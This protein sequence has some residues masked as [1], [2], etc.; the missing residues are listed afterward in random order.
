MSYT[1]MQEKQAVNGFVFTIDGHL[2]YSPMTN[3]ISGFPVQQGI[4]I[5]E[6]ADAR[7]FY[8]NS[9]S[10]FIVDRTGSFI[11]I[12]DQSN[13]IPLAVAII[14]KADYATDII[15]FKVIRYDFNKDESLLDPA[16]GLKIRLEDNWKF[17]SKVPDWIPLDAESRSRWIPIMSKE[18]EPSIG[19]NLDLRGGF[20]S[21]DG[22]SIPMVLDTRYQSNNRIQRIFTEGAITYKYNNVPVGEIDVDN[23]IEKY[24]TTDE[25]LID[26]LDR[27]NPTP[28]RPDCAADYSTNYP[29]L[30]PSGTE[31]AL[32]EPWFIDTEAI[33]AKIVTTVTS[34]INGTLNRFNV[35]RGIDN[36]PKAG[37]SQY[38][39]IFKGMPYPIGQSCKLYEVDNLNLPFKQD[40]RVT[41]RGI[42]ENIPLDE[43]LAAFNLELSS[44]TFTARVNV[45]VINQA[46]TIERRK[47]PKREIPDKQF[48]N[49]FIVSQSNVQDTFQWV[50]IG[51]IALPLVRIQDLDYLTALDDTDLATTYF[52]NW[53]LTQD[54]LD[55]KISSTFSS[56]FTDVGYK[57]G[58]ID[59]YGTTRAVNQLYNSRD[60]VIYGPSNEYE[61]T[62]GNWFL[63][64]LLSSPPITPINSPW[65]YYILDQL[66]DS[67]QHDNFIQLRNDRDIE[68]QTV[69]LNNLAGEERNFVTGY[70]S[71]NEP[72]LIHLFQKFCKG[73]GEDDFPP[74]YS[75]FFYKGSDDSASDTDQPNYAFETSIIDVILQVL[76]STGSGS[77]EVDTLRY[78]TVAGTNGPWDLIPR[79]MALGIPL[80]DI[81]LDSFVKVLQSRGGM[82]ALAVSNIYIQSG[83]DDP[84]KFLE[85]QILKPFFLSIATNSSGKII[86]IDISDV[87]FGPETKAITSDKFAKKSGDKTRVT[88]S[89]EAEDLVDSFTY[90]WKE[91]SRSN[92]D[93]PYFNRTLTSSGVELTASQRSTLSG[94]RTYPIK[95]KARVFPRIQSS[96]IKFELNYAP[97]QGI[98]LDIVTSYRE[99]VGATALLYLSRFNRIVPR[100]SFELLWDQDSPDIGDTIS[101]NLDPIPDKFG[102]V[103]NSSKILIGK[104]I[105]IKVD[106]KAKVA[107]Y[108]AILTDSTLISTD[109]L[110]NITTELIDDEPLNPNRWLVSTNLFCRGANPLV[111]NNGNQVFRFDY[112][113]FLIGSRVII[114]DRNWR[115]IN[116]CNI[117]DVTID[118]TVDPPEA[119]IE[120]DDVTSFAPQ[121][122]VT[123][124]TIGDTTSLYKQFLTWFEEGQIYL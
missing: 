115:Y 102:L 86:L 8:D 41:Y 22:I 32:P 56:G 72:E 25:V 42:V 14:L 101:F 67:A 73:Y 103:N 65:G 36:T 119:T 91:P 69:G 81:D 124:A 60:L 111:D 93:D 64:G 74:V 50:K 20:G 117:T 77:V 16:L 51:A 21:V 19:Q 38:T 7:Y 116:D 118:N 98:G 63:I 48:Y 30:N 85:E 29:F 31:L 66:G 1:Y 34:D 10:P 33:I 84:Q 6:V 15:Q 70:F 53:D 5:W 17:C 3:V 107:N 49:S 104:I 123:L 12:Y 94:D 99:K 106:R 46:S 71:D 37:H 62:V 105:D 90:A 57:I 97:S 120:F 35:T 114:W 58:F 75:R 82:N 52:D 39:V 23:V 108:T 110:W 112:S 27:G 59:R 96:P 24:L 113:E 40:W 100:A 79:E 68:I 61:V 55:V 95:S 87:L 26:V 88:L 89:Y 45:G 9:R 109:L 13:D 4:G 122:R 80:E 83:K 54:N 78:R 28:S 18:I 43:G 47:T 76:T 11:R 44:L 92:W 121:Y 2:T